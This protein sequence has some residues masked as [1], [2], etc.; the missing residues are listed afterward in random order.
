MTR[1]FIL[2]IRF[3][4]VSLGPLLGGACRFQPSCSQY[5]I[6]ALDQFGFVRG[7]WLGLGRLFRC[8]PFH[9][10]GFDPVPP[11][12]MTTGFEGWRAPI[13]GRRSP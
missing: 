2:F 6:E 13:R 8:H 9:R 3:Y 4:Q 1:L 10:G 11:S 5:W 7:T 12:T